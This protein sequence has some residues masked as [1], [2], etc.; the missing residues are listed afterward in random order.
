MIL[1]PARAT[2]AA[3]IARIANGIIADTLVTFTTRLREP[4]EIAREIAARL[5][6]YVIAEADGEVAGYASYG[7]FRSGPGYGATCEWT[8]HLADPFQERG[9]GRQLGQ[10]LMEI[11]RSQGVH[12]IVGGISSANS[13]G[14]AFH[15]ALGFSEVGRLPEVGRKNGE[16]LDLILMQKILPPR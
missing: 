10:N 1:R 6:A 14:I 5:P 11:A 3:G 13:A 8:I 9:L 16:W 7:P 2:D 4:D 12:V 15:A